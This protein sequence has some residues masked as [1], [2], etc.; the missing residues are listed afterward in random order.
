[1]LSLSTMPLIFSHKR[2]ILLIVVI[3]QICEPYIKSTLAFQFPSNVQIKTTT[4]GNNVQ[5][6]FF[7]RSSNVL[8]NSIDDKLE[9][10]IPISSNNNNN[11]NNIMERRNVFKSLGLFITTTT[12]TSAII[13]S[14]SQ[15]AEAAALLSDTTGYIPDMVGGF[16]KPKGVGGLTKKIRK[17]GDIMVG[18]FIENDVILCVCLCLCLCVLIY[19]LYICHFFY[20]VSLFF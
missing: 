17:V 4:F 16:K 8:H 7:G 2:S 19:L 15:V 1:M 3:I 11:N 18:T 5:N 20:Q 13:T 6:D 14:K 10:N 12:T 9:E